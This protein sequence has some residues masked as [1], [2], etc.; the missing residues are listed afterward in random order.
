MDAGGTARDLGCR[1]TMRESVSV[2]RRQPRLSLLVATH[3]TLAF[4]WFHKTFGGRRIAVAGLLLAGS[5]VARPHQPICSELY[6]RHVCES[7]R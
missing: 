7:I 6:R 1:A 2:R 3:A 5:N 4:E